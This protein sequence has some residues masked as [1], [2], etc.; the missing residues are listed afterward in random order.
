LNTFARVT[1]IIF[2]VLGLV[3]VLIGVFFLARGLLNPAPIAPSLFGG[4]EL[5]AFLLPLRLFVGSFMSMQGLML[6]AVG[7]ALW[8]LASIAEHSEKSA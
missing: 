3:I 1:G 7:Q 5:A 4:A 2:I 8:L 6:A